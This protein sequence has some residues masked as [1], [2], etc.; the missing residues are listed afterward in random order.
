MMPARA[1]NSAP[2]LPLRSLRTKKFYRV[3]RET[4]A[5][6]MVSRLQYFDWVEPQFKPES[7]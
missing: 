6:P 7:N 2:M 1:G 3:N 5:F 4:H